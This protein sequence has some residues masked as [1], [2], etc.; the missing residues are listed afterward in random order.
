M[1]TADIRKLANDAITANPSIMETARARVAI[2]VGELKI[3]V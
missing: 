1:S 3:D 2:T